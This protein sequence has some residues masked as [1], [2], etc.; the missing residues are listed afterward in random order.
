MAKKTKSTLQWDD[1]S[2]A[3]TGQHSKRFNAILSTMDD[4]E[5]MSNYLK[6]LEYV[7]PKI[8]RQEIV[9]ETVLDRTIKVEYVESVSDKTSKE[10]ED[11]GK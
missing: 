11:T 8:Q 3:V 9:E 4:E 1:L 10:D 5:F 7:K 6:V 2:K